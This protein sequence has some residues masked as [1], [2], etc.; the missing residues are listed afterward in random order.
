[1]D[2][3]RR[4]AQQHGVSPGEGHR[5]GIRAVR[6]TMDAA[7]DRGL[8]VITIFAFSTENWTRPQSEV[9]QIMALLGYALDV[10]FRDL[11]SRRVR[12][13]V[14]GRMDNVPGELAA[15]LRASV[16]RTSANSGATLNLAFNYGARAE[17]V[18]AVKSIVRD[19]LP[20][21]AIDEQAMSQRMYTAGLPD[22]DLVIR[23]G[24]ESRISNFLLWQSAYAEFYV[25]Q[26]LWP[27][28]RAEDLDLAMQ[29]YT[30][31]QR[32]FGR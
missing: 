14:S 9:E 26:T 19:G 32:R 10:E 29:A 15:K 25:S 6:R 24:G 5:E 7:L 12:F 21:E 23:S 17:I 13:A 16:A 4:W 22:P 20:A 2:G 1:M 30:A 28:F 18:D 31:R 3:N 8:E 11:E 27:D